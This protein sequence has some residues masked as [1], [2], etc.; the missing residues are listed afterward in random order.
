[1]RAMENTFSGNPT[2][3]SGISQLSI[4]EVTT[5]TEDSVFRVSPSS[6][7][8]AG[9]VRLQA[10][11]MAVQAEEAG[12]DTCDLRLCYLGFRSSTSTRERIRSSDNLDCWDGG[13]NE[14]SNIT[15]Q[16]LVT[17][18]IPVLDDVERTPKTPNSTPPGFA[19]YF[20]IENKI[21]NG[22][23]QVD[24]SYSRA[25]GRLPDPLPDY[26]NFGILVFKHAL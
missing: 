1:M 15:S 2:A 16:D 14:P 18:N 21:V 6:S 23:G 10:E 12:L 17:V 7:Q 8:G 24:I 22:Q 13:Y 5:E 9:A 20:E 11:M 3:A 4:R 26:L 19:Y 25:W